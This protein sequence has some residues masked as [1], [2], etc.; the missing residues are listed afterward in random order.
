MSPRNIASALTLRLALLL[1]APPTACEAS[2]QAYH[3]SAVPAAPAAAAAAAAAADAAATAATTV[4]VQMPV[5]VFQSGQD[6]EEY[7]GSNCTVDRPQCSL[8]LLAATIPS[9][10]EHWLRSSA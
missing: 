1:L 7:W 10:L 3:S 4:A 2:E 9:A 8:C 5:D 6:G